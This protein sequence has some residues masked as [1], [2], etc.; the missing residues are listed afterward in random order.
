MP[1]A[2][3]NK[4]QLKLSCTTYLLTVGSYLSVYTYLTFTR[5]SSSHR[6][7]SL[8]ILYQHGKFTND[9][10]SCGEF[11]GGTSAIVSGAVAVSMMIFLCHHPWMIL[12]SLLHHQTQP[13]L[14][15]PTMIFVRV[16]HARAC[17]NVV[18]LADV[19]PS[20]VRSVSSKW[21]DLPP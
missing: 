20:F 7:L 13:Q 4:S 12:V 5:A 19:G 11:D 1:V 15:S 16:S 2:A 3:V 8:F 6:P 14:F 17:I 18:R 9:S 21:A 10:S